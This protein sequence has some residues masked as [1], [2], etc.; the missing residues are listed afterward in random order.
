MKMLNRRGFLTAAGAGLLASKTARAQELRARI[1]A[2][3]EYLSLSGN[4]SPWC[5]GAFQA[6]GVSSSP[7]WSEVSLFEV[8]NW[9]MAIL[10]ALAKG[11]DPA[12]LLGRN[13]ISE[14]MALLDNPSLPLNAYAWGII[15]LRAVGVPIN[16]PTLINCR[17]R[18]LGN[19]DENLGWGADPAAPNSNDTAAVLLALADLGLTADVPVIQNG[20]VAL[21]SYQTPSGGFALNSDLP[22][23]A[24]SD[25][26]AIAALNRL[27]LDSSGDAISHLI[28]LQ[29][30]DGSFNF[31]ADYDGQSM[32][33]ATTT[34][35][36]LV[37]LA[38][39]AWP[40]QAGSNPPPDP[41]A[42]GLP[43]GLG[44]VLAGLAAIPALAAWRF[45]RLN[46]D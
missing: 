39:Q 26:W 14:L 44:A 38:E 20:A 10:A 41:E 45:N 3:L 4:F 34:A 1:W 16:H 5:F 29:A 15:A 11:L 30:L 18:L 42:P 40:T 27:G 24:C 9:A 36:A 12:N 25:A 43:L 22:A 35:Y 21:Y 31:Q 17:D 2:A 7:A 19:Q 28:S 33:R 13:L 32:F 37:A 6:Y 23:D 46:R 8:S